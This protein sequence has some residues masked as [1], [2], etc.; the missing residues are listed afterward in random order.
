LAIFRGHDELEIYVGGNKVG[1]DKI[2]NI[3]IANITKWSDKSNLL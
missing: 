2:R 3:K 1:Y